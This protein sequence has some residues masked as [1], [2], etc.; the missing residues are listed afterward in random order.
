MSA[1]I[2]A[3]MISELRITH[4]QEKVLTRHLRY[5]ISQGFCPSWRH[6][7]ILYNGHSEVNVGSLSWDYNGQKAINVEWCQTDIDTEVENQMSR[8][9]QSHNVE[10]S[11]IKGVQ[12]I[13]GGDHGD[14]AF[15]LE[16]KLQ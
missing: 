6:V 9:L 10:P 5:H 14:T 7:E 12:V 13:V 16:Q 3:A 1:T 15:Q 4:K 11:T 2:Y 8:V